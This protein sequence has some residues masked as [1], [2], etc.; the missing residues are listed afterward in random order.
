MIFVD[1]NYFLRFLLND[2]SVQHQKVKKLFMKAA[3]GDVSLCTSTIVFFEIF[4]VLENVY[5]KSKHEVTEILSKLLK[6]PFLEIDEKL[7]IKKALMLYEKGTIEFEDYYN[8]V[9]AEY[10]NAHKFASF[11]KKLQKVLSAD[12]QL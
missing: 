5:Q 3:N 4:W 2:N 8:I 11:D 7:Q 12:K 10:K 6:L 9:Y 1:T